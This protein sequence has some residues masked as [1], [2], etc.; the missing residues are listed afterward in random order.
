M[1]VIYLPEHF[2]L[3]LHTYMKKTNW[4]YL[5][6]S[7]TSEKLTPSGISV[8]F[9]TLRKV[10]GISVYPH[11][12]RHDYASNCLRAWVDIYTTASQMGH[13]RISTTELY[14][15]MNDEDKLQKMQL[16]K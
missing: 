1:R 14:L 15:C 10:S 3:S 12:L 16:L 13:S 8:L 11:M 2:S 6:T 4:E 7:R 5:F 9:Q